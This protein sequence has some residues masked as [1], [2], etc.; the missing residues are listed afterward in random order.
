MMIKKKTHNVTSAGNRRIRNPFHLYTSS[1]FSPLHQVARVI[2]Q[3]CICLERGTKT[4]VHLRSLKGIDKIIYHIGSKVG[5]VFLKQKQNITKMLD[6]T[7]MQ[8]T[9][10]TESGELKEVKVMKGLHYRYL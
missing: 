6:E 2:Y 10:E 7:K 8:F 4:E 1:L 9:V 3:G 5:R